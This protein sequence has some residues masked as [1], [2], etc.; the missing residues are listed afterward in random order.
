VDHS[1]VEVKSSM[2]SLPVGCATVSSPDWDGS[3][4]RKL[5]TLE[6]IY[7][8]ISDQVVS[9]RMEVLEWIIIFLIAISIILPF[10]SPNVH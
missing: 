4:L 6:G 3:I 5:E 7:Q 1:T 9:R 2:T 10:V 8:K